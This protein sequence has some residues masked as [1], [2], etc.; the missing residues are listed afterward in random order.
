MDMVDDAPGA[1]STLGTTDLGESAS[2]AEPKWARSGC[3]ATSS[4]L[5]RCI[6]ES[7]VEDPEPKISGVV[8]AD[9]DDCVAN[10]GADASLPLPGRA[11]ASSS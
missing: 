9:P 3:V 1:A 11:G 4:D 5:E 7:D 6:D 8:V 10:P 2:A